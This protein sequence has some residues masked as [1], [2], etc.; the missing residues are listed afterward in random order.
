MEKM[1]LE[2]TILKLAEDKKYKA[3]REVLGVM[4]AFD[5]A[6]VFDRVIPAEKRPVLFRLLPKELAAEVFVEL[7]DDIKQELIKSFSD[8]ELTDVIDELYVDDAADLVDEMP[9]N[10]VKRILRQASPD[11]RKMINEILR[12]PD[13]S[14]GS[15]MNTEYISLRAT[16]SVQHAIE[17]IRTTGFD[18][19][20]VNTLYVIDKERH[21]IGVVSIRDLLFSQSDDLIENVMDTCAII[22]VNTL[23]DKEN[24]ALTFK[25]YDLTEL[26]VTDT[27]NRLVGIVT[28]DDA[29]DVLQQEATEDIEKMAAITPSDKPYFK[30]SATQTFAKRIPWL[31]LLMISATF[32]GIIISQFESSLGALPILTAFIPMLMDTGGNSGSQAS[33]TVIRGIS[34]GDIEFRDILKVV[35]KE[36]RVAIMCGLALAVTAFAKVYLIDK[37]IMGKEITLLIALVI[38]LTLL[39]TVI[40]A[41]IVGC[42]LPLF[43]KKAGFD[44]AVMASPFIT[45]IVDALSLLIYFWFANLILGL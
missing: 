34:L 21:L 25:K 43:A 30:I 41:K 10:V 22:S 4:N 1:T 6:A 12:Y 37:L 17:H 14:A 19:E 33:V 3:L 2:K 16:M 20:T 38:S 7:D 29:I 9:A 36:S 23:D 8:S 44:P 40:I 27:E 5:V 39:V 24:V 31:L 18:K 28:V 45:T 32:T 11:M 35:F 13:D 15:I 42:T 26:P